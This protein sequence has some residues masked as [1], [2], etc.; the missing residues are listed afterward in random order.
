MPSPSIAFSLIERAQ[1]LNEQPVPVLLIHAEELGLDIVGSL[2][3]RELVE[4]ILR[5]EPATAAVARVVGASEVEPVVVA[6]ARLLPQRS[7]PSSPVTRTEAEAS[8]PSPSVSS[9]SGRQTAEELASDEDLARRLH[10][11]EVS[12]VRQQEAEARGARRRRV[13]A[14]VGASS[15]QPR[16][17]SV[18]A[19][20]SSPQ[21]RARLPGD[22]LP[23][24]EELS[25]MGP[26]A[27]ALLLEAMFMNEMP[28]RLAQLIQQHQSQRPR[29]L[30]PHTIQTGTVETTFTAED[31]T[32]VIGQPELQHCTVCLEVFKPGDEL[33]IL[34]CLHR[35]HRS[36]ID[37]WLQTNPNCPVCKHNICQPQPQ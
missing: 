31:A 6:E 2:E 14:A 3:K 10:E 23:P 13:A 37:I 29:G 17:R 30:N 35:Y 15:P 12:A 8:R 22:D 18:S 20:A 1:W 27:V 4:C 21:A 32:R 5:S 34:P 19:A 26:D 28:N 33:R 25:T 7:E 16:A 36:C 11:E 24:A 9:H